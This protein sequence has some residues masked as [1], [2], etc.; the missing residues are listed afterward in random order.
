M[1]KKLIALA[2]S[3]ALGIGASSVAMAQATVTLSGAINYNYGYFDNGGS[4]FAAGTAPV[5]TPAPKVRYDGLANQESEWVLT[6]E[7]ALGG[8]MSAYFRCASS[9]DLAG[10]V[11][12]GMCARTSYLGLKGNFGSINF[13]NNDTPS[14]RQIALYDPFPISA[15]FGQGGQMWNATASNT[16][17][18]ATPA[19]FSRRQQ[20]LITYDMK[21][22]NGFDAAIAFTATNEASAATSASTIQKARM[23]SG[24]VNYTNGPLMMGANYER[25]ID[26]NPAGLAAYSGGNDSMWSVGIAYTFMG[27]LKLSAIYNKINYGNITGGLTMDVGTYG[28]YADW[29]ISG[30]HRLKFGYGNQGSTKGTYNGMTA[31]A[32]TQVGTWT[33]NGGAGQTGAQ[34]YVV[35]YNY[36]LSKRTEVG[37]AYVR[38]NNERFANTTLGTGSIAANYGET[39]TWLGMI[40]RHRF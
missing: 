33:G 11:A 39:Q 23:W 4:G 32:N 20:N 25:H 27:N 3:S 37:G 15:V 40:M 19:S 36:A 7:E 26:Y 1:N 34:K 22:M 17:N 21:T 12:I 8:G 24:M 28:L 29:A 30:P 18:G 10:T 31:V 5:V 13:G 16:A 38:L 2:V 9:L 35:E 6:G 14:K